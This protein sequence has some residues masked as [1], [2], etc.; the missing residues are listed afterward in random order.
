MAFSPSESGG[1]LRNLPF[2]HSSGGT[3]VPSVNY[4]SAP[5]CLQALDSSE[6]LHWP[7]FQLHRDSQK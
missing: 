1:G 4:S 6:Q 3:P 5:A 2:T 7:G